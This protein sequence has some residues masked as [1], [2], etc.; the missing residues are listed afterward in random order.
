M[1]REAFKRKEWKYIGLIPIYFRFFGAKAPLGSLEQKVKAKKFR[2][3]M[4]LPKL[5][6]DR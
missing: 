2:S 4:I 3:G 5:I 1:L 6:D